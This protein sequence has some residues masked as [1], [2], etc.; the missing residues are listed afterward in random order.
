[1][2][3]LVTHVT[4]A[5]SENLTF[6]RSENAVFNFSSFIHLSARKIATKGFKKEPPVEKNGA[7]QS[8]LFQKNRFVG[9]KSIP[10][11]EFQ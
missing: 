9:D 10:V 3:G 2:V 1:M 6:A 7:D 4:F 8:G 5:R 11:V